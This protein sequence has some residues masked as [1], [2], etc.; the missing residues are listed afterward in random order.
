MLKWLGAV[1]LTVA[2]GIGL[3]YTMSPALG[4]LGAGLESGKR[5][6]IAEYQQMIAE[7]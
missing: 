4:V 3:A 5:A 6:A 1:V 7:R 2:W